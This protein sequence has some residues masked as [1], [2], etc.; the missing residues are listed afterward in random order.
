MHCKTLECIVKH[1]S[2][3]RVTHDSGCLVSL[4]PRDF[5]RNALK[6]IGSIPNGVPI[7]R[8]HMSMKPNDVRFFFEI[9]QSGL[10]KCKLYWKILFGKIS[11][12]ISNKSMENFM[13]RLNNSKDY[14]F[15]IVVL[16]KHNSL[17][18]KNNKVYLRT[19]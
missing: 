10:S 18:I 15:L 16:N 14:S 11:I 13:N 5:V 8:F 9:K 3:R 7:Y 2:F 1:W 6:S 12:W 17:E 19:H 4:V